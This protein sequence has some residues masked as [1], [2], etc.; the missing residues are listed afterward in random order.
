MIKI[1]LPWYHAGKANNKIKER[2]K[3]IE[4]GDFVNNIDYMKDYEK[5]SF[6][7]L[8]VFFNK[9]MD[10]KKSLEDKLKTSLFSVTIGI[11]VLTSAISFLFNDGIASIN[12]L[13]KGMIFFLGSLA[14]IYMILAGVFAIKTISGFISVY[15]LFPEDMSL[16]IQE[17]KEAIAISAE[18]N[19]LSNLIRQNLMNASYHC[20]INSLFIITV[21][22]FLIGFASFAEKT[23]RE[24]S[25]NVEVTIQPNQKNIDLLYSKMYQDN[26][27]KQRS[28]ESIKSELEKQN[29]YI[30]S[31]DQKIINLKKEVT[32]SEQEIKDQIY[33]LE[34]S[35]KTSQQTALPSLK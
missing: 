22:F 11:T 35:N 7:D 33:D 1:L 21:F 10:V 25:I 32:I 28:L 14:I 6:K 26:E 4:E 9:T 3:S 27:S 18:L 19:S 15:Q 24:D 5:L 2:I 20:I 17:R 31:I 13:Y 29:S 12:V 8:E 16:P 30:Q 23:K 34:L